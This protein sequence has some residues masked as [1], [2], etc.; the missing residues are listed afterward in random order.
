MASNRYDD[1]GYFPATPCCKRAVHEATAILEKLG[2]EI[3]FFQLPNLKAIVDMYF[4]H[5][6]AD[7]GETSLDI[8][9]G[10]ILDQVRA[11]LNFSGPWENVST[12]WQYLLLHLYKTLPN[13]ALPDQFSIPSPYPVG[14]TYPS[15]ARGILTPAPNP[16]NSKLNKLPEILPKIWQKQILDR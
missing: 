14:G 5:M 12:L 13:L 4:D 15:P 2:H 16:D 8:W 11:Q 10:E 1:D 7:D 9:E 6:L 3:V